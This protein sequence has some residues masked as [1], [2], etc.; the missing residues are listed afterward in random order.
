MSAL[1]SAD[2]NYLFRFCHYNHVIHA[3]KMQNEFQFFN[4]VVVIAIVNY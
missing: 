1:L 2:S 3:Y 4:K